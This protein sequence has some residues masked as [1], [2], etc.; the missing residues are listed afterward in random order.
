MPAR[1]AVTLDRL[2]AD[3]RALGLHRGDRLALHSSLKSIGFVLGGPQTVIRA[4]MEVVGE[5]GTL[6]MPV[7]SRPA[8][9]FLVQETPSRTGLVT[10]T[11]RRMP[12]VLRSPH[13]THSVAVWGAD[14][15]EIA[16]GHEQATGLGVDSPFHRLARMGGLVVLVGCDSRS[17]SIIHVAEA[18]AQVPY[19]DVFYPGYDITMT[20]VY[21]DGRERL[22]EP[23]ENPG[24]SSAFLIVEEEMRRRGLIRE[25]LVGQARTMVM[26]G[27]DIIETALA[28][29]AKDPA[30]LLCQRPDCRVCPPSRERLR[31]GARPAGG[32]A[33]A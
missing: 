7:F 16:R 20:V 2:V 26:K 30:S 18:I 25:G 14:A 22:V 6:L 29:L 28:L 5:E 1:F 27:M 13:P 4:L 21:P 31:P 12:G 33:G 11:F 19:L 17:S 8:P 3:F 15:E 24:D 23:R 32:P 9:R 10:E